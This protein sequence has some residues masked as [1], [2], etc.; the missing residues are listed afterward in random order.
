M[1]NVLSRFV[2]SAHL[3][4]DLSNP[5]LV[6]RIKKKKSLLSLLLGPWSRARPAT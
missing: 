6:Y 5:F 2:P 4:K 1:Q 3:S